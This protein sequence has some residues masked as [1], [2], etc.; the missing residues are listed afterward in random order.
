MRALLILCMFFGPALVGKAGDG[1]LPFGKGGD[2]TLPF[3]MEG[4]VGSVGLNYRF[5]KPES[6]RRE[7]LRRDTEN[8]I[9]QSFYGDLENSLCPSGFKEFK[10]RGIVVLGGASH[11]ITHVCKNSN[12]NQIITKSRVVLSGRVKATS[13]GKVFSGNL[14][15][16]SSSKGQFILRESP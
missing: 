13:A 2:G 11:A 4:S 16:S 10:V 5:D 7:S 12:K 8:H 9:L 15:E 14:K 3:G 6:L 1:T